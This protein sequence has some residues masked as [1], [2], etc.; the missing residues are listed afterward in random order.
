[1]TGALSWRVPA[2]VACPLLG[3][4]HQVEDEHRGDSATFA[5]CSPDLGFTEPLPPCTPASPCMATSDG[6]AIESPS[7]SAVCRTSSSSHPEHDDGAAFTQ[8]DADGVTRSWCQFTPGG[9]GPWPLVLWFHGAG[10]A[11]GDVYDYTSVREKAASVALGDVPGFVLVSIQGR[12]LHWPTV[13]ARD[14]SHHDIYHRAVGAPSGNADVALADEIVD[15]L[16]S[17]GTVDP[18]RIYAMGW[19]NGGFFAQLYAIARRET[20]SAGGNRVAAAAVFSAADPFDDARLDADPSCQLDPYPRSSVPI[21]VVG[22][23]C[24]LVACDEPQADGLRDD[25]YALPPG[26]VVSTW[27]DDLKSKVGA[28]PERRIGDF[29]GDEVDECTAAA[30]CGLAAATVNHVMWP[31]GVSDGSGNDHEADMLDF[32]GR[33]EVSGD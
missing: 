25:G 30:W 8:V 16:V 31:D 7:A 19:S 24:D 15:N 5:E 11:A 18:Q 21:F 1:M 3:C 20:P 23:A 28:S 10:G 14:G 12:N 33:Y 26:A 13:D 6:I 29:G 4:G 9:D 32:L 22:R 17:S 27:L 2:L